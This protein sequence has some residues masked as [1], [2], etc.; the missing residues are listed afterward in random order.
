MHLLGLRVGRLLS[1]LLPTYH[2]VGGVGGD[3]FLF[4]WR[5]G[6]STVLAGARQREANPNTDVTTSTQTELHDDDASWFN[7]D[8]TS[9]S[10]IKDQSIKPSNKLFIPISKIVSRESVCRHEIIERIM[11]RSDSCHITLRLQH[12]SSGVRDQRPL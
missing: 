6:L 9:L 7:E 12:A 4:T 1:P 8:L 11:F 3:G 2:R 10:V 5:R